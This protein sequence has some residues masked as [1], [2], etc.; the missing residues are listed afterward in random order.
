M[1][2]L[3]WAD[4]AHMYND[5]DIIDLDGAKMRNASFDR[6]GKCLA[7]PYVKVEGMPLKRLRQVNEYL[8]ILRH[9]EDISEA[10]MLHLLD[11][12]WRNLTPDQRPKVLRVA[13][14][15]DRIAIFSQ[16]FRHDS[17]K[18]YEKQTSMPLEWLGFECFHWL[19]YQGFDLLG[20][21]EKGEATR[22]PKD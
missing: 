10:E 16:H 15:R 13:F 11:L 12:K 3:K 4:V 6:G 9:L 1:N 8:P 14:D 7:I 5:I 19:L 22:R 21:I 18:E 2:D 20:L 17:G